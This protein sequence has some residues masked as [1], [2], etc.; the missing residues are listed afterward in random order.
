LTLFE[1]TRAYTTSW[2]VLKYWKKTKL[3]SISVQKM[4]QKCI[5]NKAEETK[6]NSKLGA[7]WHDRGSIAR[8][9][10]KIPLFSVAF[11][12]YLK[13]DLDT[14]LTEVGKRNDSSYP[15]QVKIVRI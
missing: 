14:S 13:K 15:I 7:V 6:Q 12:K 2:D 10:E 4:S 8:H 9:Q 11:F 5:F 1:D 3:K